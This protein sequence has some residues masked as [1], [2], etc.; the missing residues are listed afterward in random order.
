MPFTLEGLALNNA[1]MLLIALSVF[2]LVIAVLHR[3]FRL[4]RFGV[5]IKPYLMLM[6]RTKRFNEFIGKLASRLAAF[7]RV[8]FTVGCFLA[9]GELMFTL[10]FLASNFATSL[11][12]GG[13][14][15]VVPLI[16]GVTISVNALPYFVISAVIVF[17]LHE[18]AHG[19]AAVVE[20]VKLKS[21]GVIF[22]ILVVGGFAELDDESVARAERLS[23]MR[24][25]SAG[26][27]VNL[28]FGILAVLMIANF[29]LV[30]SPAFQPSQG[31]V[32]LDVL[33]GTPAEKA[34]L[35]VGDVILAINGVRIHDVL[36]FHQ[37][38][39]GAPANSTLILSLLRGDVVVKSSFHPLNSSRAFL[40]VRT[41]DYFPPKAWASALTYMFP[42]HLYNF[43]SW[44]EVLSI[45][46]ALI[47]MLPIPFLDG[48]GFFEA[49][50]QAPALMRRKVFLL[51]REMPLSEA[52]LNV[53]RVASVLLLCLNMVQSFNAGGFSFP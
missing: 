48:N 4:D 2:W 19:I 6:W 9:V 49:L 17:C 43:L 46:A 22:F 40:G 25:L 15:P 50:L 21:I 23:R 1:L 14:S 13:I 41:F 10:K 18:L 16:P 5:E 12:G 45:S 52:L 34:G 32:V 11:T 44:F 51:N 20:G 35:Q 39:S 30:I 33:S 28:L 53:V 36:S 37:F 3:I 7:W 26:S 27:T 8:F 42:W 47:N 38:M 31:V 29:A 24:L